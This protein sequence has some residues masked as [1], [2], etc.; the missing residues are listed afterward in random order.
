MKRSNLG[1]YHRSVYS[2]PEPSQSTM[3]GKTMSR[4]IQSHTTATWRSQNQ[5]TYKTTVPRLKTKRLHPFLRC[6]IRHT[7]QDS[8]NMYDK[9]Q[10]TR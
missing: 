2:I 9:I 3:C 6:Q 7:V 8:S 1:V 10:L 5:F 4:P